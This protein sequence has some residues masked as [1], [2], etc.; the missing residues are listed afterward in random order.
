MVSVWATSATADS[1]TLSDGRVIDLSSIPGNGWP[2]AK[3]RKARDFLQDKLDSRKLAADVHPNE[4]TKGWTDEQMQ[5]VYDGRMW[6]DGNDLMSRSV[7]VDAVLWDG[8]KLSLA[9]RNP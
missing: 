9:L 3:L 7:V 1:I 5:S 4:E 8:V 6:W 2:D